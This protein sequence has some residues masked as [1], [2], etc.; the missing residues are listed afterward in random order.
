MVHTDTDKGVRLTETSNDS[1]LAGLIRTQTTVTN[2]MNVYA[3]A[4]AE[5]SDCGQSLIS[6]G[7]ELKNFAAFIEK[8]VSG[9]TTFVNLQLDA[10]AYVPLKNSTP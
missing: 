8:A 6:K 4:D 9:L 5:P 2:H 7:C 3:G 10:H 1:Y